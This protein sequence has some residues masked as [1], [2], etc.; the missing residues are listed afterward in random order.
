MAAVLERQGH[1]VEVVDQLFDPATHLEEL[2]SRYF[3]F[4]YGLEQAEERLPQGPFDAVVVQNTPFTNLQRHDEELAGMLG[5][6]KARYGAPLFLADGYIGGQHRIAAI[7]PEVL[8]RYG[9]DQYAPDEAETNLLINERRTT[10]DEQ[11]AT[12]LLLAPEQVLLQRQLVDNFFNQI[13]RRPD[14]GETGLTLGTHTSRGCL[15]ACTFC[16]SNPEA[17]PKSFRPYDLT[18]LAQ[19]W[20]MLKETIGLGRLVVL[21]ELANGSKS[22]FENLLSVVEELGIQISFPNGVRA[23]LLSDAQIHRLAG[24]IPRLSVSAESGSESVRQG[25]I[26]KRMKEGHIRRVAE[27]CQREGIPLLVHYMV[28]YPDETMEQVNETFDE[29]LELAESTGAEPAIQFATPLPN[30]GLYKE[31]AANNLLTQTEVGDYLPFF[32]EGG[33]I[34][35]KHL[36][37]VQ[38]RESLRWFAIRKRSLRPEKIIMNLTYVCNNQCTFCATGNR[39]KGHADLSYYQQLLDEHYEQGIRLVDFD[40]GEPT[41][42]PNFLQVIRHARAKGYDKINLTTNGRLMAMEKN[43]VKILRSGITELLISFH[44]HTA[45][46]H[47][48]Q[49]QAPGSYEQTLSAIKNSIKFGANRT[50]RFGVNFT[51][52]AHNAPSI[53]DYTEFVYGLGVRRIN[54]QFVTPFGRA[55]PEDIPDPADAAPYVTAALARFGDKMDIQVIN[56]PFCFL[57]G[58]EKH[59]AGDVAKAA[60]TMVFVSEQE[61]NLG[62]FLEVTRKKTEVCASCR[63]NIACDGFYDFDRAESVAGAVPL[64]TAQVGGRG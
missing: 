44:G 13:R 38:L 63:F 15:Y 9:F 30:T 41:L 58:Y 23:D 12:A 19:H 64:S 6:M 60:R 1:E 11:R 31:L 40:G 43:A 54:I 26:G 53:E 52:T 47:E 48:H 4:G 36:D 57:P 21:D 18:A 34:H 8:D 24:R 14:F 25:M 7:T 5:R 16:T 56:L 42:Y 39:F 32:H 61:V 51:L 35:L 20:A 50:L 27:S 33:L 37:P 22:H 62:K 17:D 29:A 2:D 10:K 45:D 28:G 59:M 46:F 49:T 3:W 55:H